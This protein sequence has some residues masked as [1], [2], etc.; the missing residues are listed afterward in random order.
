[1]KKPGGIMEK[2]IDIM[3]LLKTSWGILKENAMFFVLYYGLFLGVGAVIGIFAV[4]SIL[5]KMPLLLFFVP[6]ILLGLVLVTMPGLMIG[7]L[8]AVDGQK[9]EFKDL[10]SH[11]EMI[12]PVMITAIVVAF[13]SWLGMLF[14]ILPGIYLAMV[15]MFAVY[16]VVDKKVSPMDSLK[17]SREMVKGGLGSLIAFF[18]GSM[19]LV[20]VVALISSIIPI[21]NFIVMQAVA[22]IVQIAYAVI[23]RRWTG[24]TVMAGNGSN[25]MPMNPTPQPNQPQPA[26]Q[27]S[28]QAQ[29]VQPSAPASQQHVD[30]KQA[31]TMQP[32][33]QPSA[34]A[35]MPAATPATTEP[36]SQPAP[37]RA[38]PVAASTTA[39]SPQ[40]PVT[41]T[42]PQTPPHQ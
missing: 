8:K 15:H 18:V 5:L 27:T 13:I 32:M 21:F 6:L 33:A 20:F 39:D 11:T 4:V 17:A 40:P 25:P 22:I 9:P 37:Q 1:M 14:L 3:E 34:P 26:Q 16:F 10:F 38:T 29:V 2:K 36:E 35:P 7:T 31:Q 42:Q 19:L 41:P 28:P 30:A 12:L 23:Y 24:G